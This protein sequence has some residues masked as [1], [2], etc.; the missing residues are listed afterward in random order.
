MKTAKTYAFDALV[1]LIGQS[2]LFLIGAF[3][4]INIASIV[5]WALCAAGFALFLSV[6]ARGAELRRGADFRHYML[7]SVL[8]VNI[9]ALV[10]AGITGIIE[11][12]IW[13]NHDPL[14]YV[15]TP[16]YPVGIAVGT[17]WITLWFAALNRLTRKEE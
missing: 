12:N 8:P 5:L 15:Y 10:A 16:L 4:W 7:F 6:M 11:Y 2:V 14:K 1:N 13:V 9:I 17:V 3:V